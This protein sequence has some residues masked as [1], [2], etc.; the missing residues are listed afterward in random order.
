MARLVSPAA[1]FHAT[2]GDLGFRVRG[3]QHAGVQDP[4]LLGPDQFLTFEEQDTKIA[5]VLDRQIGNGA[6]FGDLFHG[7]ATPVDGRVGKVVVHGVA[8]LCEEREYRQSL[9][10]DRIADSD[11]GKATDFGPENAPLLDTAMPQTVRCK[12]RLMP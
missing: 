10:A 12:R 7:D 9:V 4:V 5:T 8:S 6:R 3:D 11:L 1:R 2:H